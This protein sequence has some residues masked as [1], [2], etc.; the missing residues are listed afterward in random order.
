MGQRMRYDLA[1]QMED[2][3]VCSLCWGRLEADKVSATVYD[4][5]CVNPECSG[6]GFV[7]K[8]YAERRLTDSYFEAVEVRHNYGV[9]FGIDQPITKEQAMKDL[10]F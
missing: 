4:L 2:R 9:L 8:R 7:T 3:Y 10:G 6:A 5:H 1:M